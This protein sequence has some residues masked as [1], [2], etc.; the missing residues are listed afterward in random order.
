MPFSFE[1][2]T[3]AVHL[4]RS[5]AHAHLTGI[6]QWVSDPE[7]RSCLH[8]IASI[9]DDL[10]SCVH[11]LVRSG[12][13]QPAHRLALAEK[14]RRPIA[15]DRILRIGIYPLAANPMH[16]GHILVGLAV[17]AFLKLD[18]IVFVIAGKD[19]RKPQM[20][21]PETRHQ[22]GISV[23]ENFAPI[24]EYSPIALGT[25]LDGETNF[26]RILALNSDQRMETWYIAGMD[27]YRRK[28]LAGEPDT[29]EKL[30]RV[31]KEQESVGNRRHSISLI[32]VERGANP[33]ERGDR[34]TFLNV[35]LLPPFPIAL[36]STAARRALCQGGT[37][38]DA[39]VS[40]PYACLLTTRANGSNSGIR[41]CFD[42][43]DMMV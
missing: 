15:I 33:G 38:C 12:Q 20:T 35:H 42:G 7:C 21:A 14:E 1:T 17:M 11:E 37:L 27:H 30:E 24:F 9:A 34:E 4:I 22:L 28:N 18:K 39:V 6:M 13:I 26:G 25:R 2:D 8:E 5:M 32:F 10:L 43:T 29:L 41:E 19:D 31:V 36:S 23:L 16:W 3:A 40:L